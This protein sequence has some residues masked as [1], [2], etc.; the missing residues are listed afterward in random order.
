[1]NCK[2]KG[3][4]RLAGESGTKSDYEAMTT[5]ASQTS[6]ETA[7]AKLVVRFGDGDACRGM[8]VTSAMLKQG[9]PLLVDAELEDDVM[10]IRFDALK[11][12]DG[13]SMLGDHHYLP[14]L[15]NPGDKVGRPRKLLLAVLGLG[16]ASVQG[17]RPTVGLMA[18]GREA[19]LRKVR[20]D[21]KLYR[22]AE[23]V[24]DEA[25]QLQAGGEPPRLTLNKHCQVCEFRQRCRNQAEQADDISLLGSV[26]EKELKRYNRKGIFTLTQLSCTFRPRKRA[27]R[28]KRSG[29]TRYPALQA[30]AI[31][32]K[33]V[34]VYGTPDIPRKPMQV[35]L[36]AEG[37]EDAG[38]AY[39]LGVLV[40]E[41][42]SQKMRSFWADDPDQEAEAF[43]GFLDLLDGREDF[44][45]FYYGSY[46]RRLLQRM[47]KVVKRVKLV[48]RLLANAVNVLATIYSNV[49]FPTFSNGLKDVARYLG[50]TWTDESSSGL[51]SLV[52]RAHWEQARDQCWKDKL[53]TYNAED[54]AALRKVAEFVQAVG[55]AVRSRGERGDLSPDGPTIAWADEI[56]IPS[57]RRGWGRPNFILED[58]DRV[59][60]CAYF[61]YQREKVFLRTNAVVKR[62]CRGAAKRK[63]RFKL[64]ANREVEFKSDAC[65]RCK[66]IRL[67]L[68]SRR[69]RSKLAYDLK[70]T[71]GGIRRQVIRCAAVQYECWDC[72]LTFLPKSYKRRDKH[73]HGLKSWAVYLLVVHRI[74]LHYV[75]A[76]FEDCFGLRVGTMEVLM[77]KILMARRYRQTL[78]G[79]LARIVA[80]GLVH[81]D[82][83]EVKL[84]KSKG[85][86]WVLASMEDVLYIYRPNREADFLH[87]LLRDFKGVLV[88]D[89]YPGYESLPCEKQACLIHLIRDMNTDLM[90]SPYDDEFKSIAADFGK[91]LRSIVGTINDYG[92][93]KK[94]LH[95]HKAEVARFSRDLAARVYRSE[96]AEGY[97]KRL[98]KNEDRL[99]TFLDHDNIPWN[100]NAAEHAIKAFARFRELYDGQMSEEG[101]SDHLALLSVQQT[102]KSRGVGF[103][104]FLLSR[105]EN[106]GTF[107]DR[108]RKTNEPP[109][110]DVYPDG[111]SRTHRKV[112]EEQRTESDTP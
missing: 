98:R 96:L 65:P 37:S 39:L 79:I 20:L 53:L 102:C 5:A 86:V 17:L 60:R 58:F 83:T 111:F 45:L 23:K 8:R 40:V 78:K 91:L 63:K 85:Y 10:S 99:F 2:T 82:E 92:L 21:A 103:L 69:V 109:A 70:F 30:L 66:G 67:T 56:E 42:E 68:N 55:E 81:V 32:E 26:S 94:H 6:R 95:K 108:T 13:A 57:S 1:L 71:A 4:L 7:L 76:M 62:A 80:G 54:C 75:E 15:H 34:H 27:K 41:G 89:F 3:R 72:G 18:P 36:D 64:P 59:N 88:S 22:D 44:V 11:Q 93:K 25:R 97:Q 9:A 84:C 48:D 87:D 24:L 35:F 38:F 104:K 106:V 107:C 105:D 77:I 101:L 100:N 19:R 90:G 46:E 73:L 29:Y 14:V 61:D 31:R 52:W 16:L 74:S 112:K 43:D 110:I 12:A 33:K 47:R 49:Y 28:V 51:Q 50:C